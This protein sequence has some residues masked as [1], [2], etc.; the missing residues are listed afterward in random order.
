MAQGVSVVGLGK[1]GLCFATVLAEAGLNTIGVDVDQRTVALVNAGRSP[2]KEPGLDEL[3]AT[4]GGKRLL[5]TTS[6]RQAIDQ[7]DVTFVLVNTPSNAD[8]SF[9]N[10]YVEGALASLAAALK[11]SAKTYHV[12]VISSTVMPG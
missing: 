12:F 4:V 10:R 3:L 6:H 11:A 8:G 5:A 9:S 1:L 2:L 7:T